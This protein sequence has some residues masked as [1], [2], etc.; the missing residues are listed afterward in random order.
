[1]K[2]QQLYEKVTA[3]IVKEMEAGSVPWTR[4]WRKG[5]TVIDCMPHNSA[6]KRSYSG[7]NIP[8]L[9]SAAL[10]NGYP[11]HAWMSYRQA[12]ALGAQVRGGEKATDI[13]FLKRVT[14]KVDQGENKFGML[15]TYCVFNEAQI[16]NLP[17][18]KPAKVLTEPERHAKAEA[19]LAGIGATV[20]HGGDRACFVQGLD[21]I[22]ILDGLIASHRGRI[23]NTAG[24]SVRLSRRPMRN[25]HCSRCP[26]V[27][28]ALDT[29]V[30]TGNDRVPR[31][32]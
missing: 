14:K 16:D 10:N 32:S 18:P 27:K 9:W 17:S 30:T 11:T 2:I 4:P 23:A 26:Q 12:A 7:I 1:M 5:H 8:L 3:D 25:C 20:Q 19:F 6:T 15:R 29:S 22:K 21:L 24:D 28:C 31:K 13:V